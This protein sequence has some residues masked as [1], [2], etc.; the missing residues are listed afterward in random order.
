ME[1]EKKKERKEKKKGKKA[2]CKLSLFSLFHVL[3]NMQQ[4]TVSWE[5]SSS[6]SKILLFLCQRLSL[7]G[8]VYIS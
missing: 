4:S 5:L 3:S 1:R 6:S 7:H 2:R 8:L